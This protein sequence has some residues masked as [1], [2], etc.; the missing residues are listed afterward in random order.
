MIGIRP[1]EG[2]I[3]LDVEAPGSH[4]EGSPSG[5]ASLKGKDMP[6]AH[7]EHLTATGGTHLF[8]ST[9][10]HISKKEG[11][12]PGVD[13]RAKA[14]YVIAPGSVRKDG[15]PG[16]YTVE[17]E[18]HGPGSW[19]PAPSWLLAAAASKPSTNK[20]TEADVEGRVPTEQET[21]HARSILNKC[22][23]KLKDWPVDKGGAAA[24]QACV[25]PIA[26]LWPLRAEREK[27][28][29]AIRKII[30]KEWEKP[31][32]ENT[33]RAEGLIDNAFRDAPPL[34]LA[35]DESY[36]EKVGQ[37]M[38][39][40]MGRPASVATEQKPTTSGR[41][42]LW[43]VSE[44]Y[45]DLTD[46]Q[47]TIPGLHIG[48]GR[49]TLIIGPSGCGKSYALA[50]MLHALS[51]GEK[52]WHRFQGIDKPVKVLHLDWEQ[53]PSQVRRRYQELALGRVSRPAEGM[54]SYARPDWTLNSDE[55]ITELKALIAETGAQVVVL[56]CLTAAMR[57]VDENDVRFA[58]PLRTLG[59]LSED[60]GVDFFV[61]HHT[62]RNAAHARGTSAIEAA[63]GEIFTFSKDADGQ[64]TVAHTRTQSDPVW[65]GELPVVLE[66]KP[67][68]APAFTGAPMVVT[69]KVAAPSSQSALERALDESRQAED[70][71][72]STI[73]QTAGKGVVP[74]QLAKM[75]R[76]PVPRFREVVKKLVS[77]SKL[78][79]WGTTEVPDYRTVPMAAARHFAGHDLGS[80]GSVHRT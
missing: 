72:L 3:V 29:A 13:L 34:T 44:I 71:V 42:K 32:R 19:V 49:P 46:P 50:D 20:Q 48:I 25:W 61:V 65:L 43:S 68:P 16:V 17:G 15:H 8:F 47:Y 45:A 4:G 38:T 12:F 60:L 10:A 73:A 2:E 37:E 69:Y 76:M 14:G 57:G 22:L 59:K 55:G 79:Q 18:D 35:P 51:S 6:R 75:C 64:Y 54:L 21:S 23:T 40:A 39:A 9:D 41:S 70:L 66:K 78:H 26:G 56:D 77:A 33:E 31:W 27:H 5:S 58:E 53:G 36:F 1:R 67:Q 30:Y 74:T 28:A 24:L 62:G 52:I 63:A 7:R 11:L 80:D